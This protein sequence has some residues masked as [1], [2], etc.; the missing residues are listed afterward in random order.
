MLPPLSIL[1]YCPPFPAPVFFFNDDDRFLLIL[2]L[3]NYLFRLYGR[4]IA[5]FYRNKYNCISVCS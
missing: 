4:Y 2:V 1:S 5:R 3:K